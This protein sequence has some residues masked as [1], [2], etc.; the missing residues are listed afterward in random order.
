VDCCD[1]GT[2]WSDQLAPATWGL[3]WYR[4]RA[5]TDLI[6]FSGG[7]FELEFR[8]PKDTVVKTKVAGIVGG[9]GGV[10]GTDP[11]VVV[12]LLAGDFDTLDGTYWLRIKEE[13]SDRVY[14]W[15]KVHIRQ[16]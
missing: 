10:D 14:S 7:V 8:K 5:K 15:G 4:D 1:F 6:D 2:Y 3:H 13:N 11:N 12:T 16:A 9:N